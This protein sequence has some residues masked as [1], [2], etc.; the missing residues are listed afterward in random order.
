MRWD[1]LMVVFLFFTALVTPFE[2]A[3]LPKGRY[4]RRR[5]VCAAPP[6]PPKLPAT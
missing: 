5:A 4:D 1:L 6:A 2:V 3:F